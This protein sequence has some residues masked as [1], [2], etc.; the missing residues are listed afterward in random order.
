[1]TILKNAKIIY[2]EL[3]KLYNKNYKIFIPIISSFLLILVIRSVLALL[4]TL[5]AI[6]E[7]PIQRILFMISSTFLVIGL[8]IGF[9]KLIFN[10][11]D[12]KDF[13]TKNSINS[14]FNYFHL[15]GNYLQGLFYFY[16]ILL[17]C[18]IPTLLFIYNQY[19]GDFFSIIYNSINDPYFQELIFS[20][21]NFKSI[22]II[23]LLLV[24]PAMYV[25]IRLIFWSYYIID[26][27]CNG[28]LALKKSYI[29]TKNH[30]SEI[31]YYLFLILL[32]NLVGVISL[33]GIC[34]TIPITYVF[35]C[36]YY[37]L[38][39]SNELKSRINS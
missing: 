3:K 16:G 7:Y 22:V 39:T 18:T 21:F 27:G 25:S 36:K 17:F 15:L 34:I 29:V 31:I 5:F 26:Q 33:V 38:F 19:N 12:S 4:D 11:I 14:I 30:V 35:L 10:I 6:D 2:S 37:R 20:Y 8:E 9:T 32:F 24:M 28:Y 23:S 13:S 1:M